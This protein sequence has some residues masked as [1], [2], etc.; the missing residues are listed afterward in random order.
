ME[1]YGVVLASIMAPKNVDI[2]E[3]YELEP[4]EIVELIGNNN[5]TGVK[6]FN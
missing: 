6:L 1:S 2:L 5:L 3:P 4:Y